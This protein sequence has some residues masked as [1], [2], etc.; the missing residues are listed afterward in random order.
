[1]SSLEK[2]YGII[3]AILVMFIFP[4]LWSQNKVSE[5]EGDYLKNVV[6]DFAKTVCTKGEIDKNGYSTFL[7]HIGQIDEMVHVTMAVKKTIV[8]PEY[9]QGNF[10]GKITTYYSEIYNNEIVQNLEKDGRFEL[11]KGD[12]FQI[13]LY[14]KGKLTAYACDSVDGKERR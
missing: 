2:L 6:N 3:V 4:V 13:D 11:C 7:S 5:I 9:I 10:S 8:E 14:Q 1:M 12:I